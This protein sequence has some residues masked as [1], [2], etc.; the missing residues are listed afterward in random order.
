L[1]AAEQLV[2]KNVLVGPLPN[3]ENFDVDFAS[4]TENDVPLVITQSEFTRRMKDMSTLG[5]GMNFYGNLPD[6]FS[7]VVN[8][9][10]SLITRTLDDATK[11]HEKDLKGFSEKLDS[12]EEHKKD[13]QKAQEGKKDEEIKQ[14]EKDKLSNVETKIK[15]IEDKRKTLLEDYGKKNDLIC[16][17]TDLALLSNNMLKG[18]NLTKFV[19][20]SID[21]I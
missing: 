5:G 14:E 16:Q 8:T 20:R 19:K 17:L 18:E 4:M 15:E 7:L 2:L 3:K 11:A 13:L 9:N 10:N 6:R 1:S 21:L 12:L